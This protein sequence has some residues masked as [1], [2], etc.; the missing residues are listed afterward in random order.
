MNRNEKNS[1]RKYDSIAHHYDLTF[2]GKFTA[3]YKQK[4]LEL[5]EVP[6]GGRVLDVG[7]G[8]GS[9]INAIRQ[10]GKMDAYGID[11]SPNMIEECR[12]RYDGMHFEVSSGEEIGLSDGCFDVVIIC[13]V[14]HHL[15]DPQKFFEEAYRVLKRGGILIVGEPWNPLPIKQVMDYVLSPLLRA[16]DN[17]TFT[18]KRLRRL[19]HENGLTIQPDSYEKDFMQII[20]AK[21]M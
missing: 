17:K 5:C 4:I 15:H 6:D 11:I 1:I 3:R 9:L 18:R 8:N 2:E 20:K 16:G 19:F 10:K 12:K 14:L 7:C 21:K 13:C